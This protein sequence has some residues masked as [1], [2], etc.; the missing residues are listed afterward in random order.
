MKYGFEWNRYNL[1]HYDKDNPPPKVI[2]GY[3][4]NIFYP[5]LIDKKRI[6]KYELLPIPNDDNFCLIKFVAGPPYGIFIKYRR[7]CFQNCKSWM[8]I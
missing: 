7:Y 1:T 4:F 2:Q 5:D 8:G 6:P 3:K